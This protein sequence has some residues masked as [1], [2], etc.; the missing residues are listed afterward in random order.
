MKLRLLLPLLF[1]LVGC[2]ISPFESVSSSNAISQSFPLQIPLSWDMQSSPQMNKAVGQ[3]IDLALKF[4]ASQRDFARARRKLDAVSWKYKSPHNPHLEAHLI[5]ARGIIDAIEG[6]GTGDFKSAIASF[7]QAQG[8]YSRLG[9]NRQAEVVR[10]NINLLETRQKE[11][12]Q[13]LP[14]APNGQASVEDRQAL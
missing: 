6:N 1:L 13:A 11:L 14:E 4:A 2:D 8:L 5:C 12:K 10:Y 7:Q 3:E 9:H